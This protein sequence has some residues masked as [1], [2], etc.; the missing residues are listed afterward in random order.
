M[1]VRFLVTLGTTADCAV[2]VQL[3]KGFY[4]QYL[5]ADRG[6][7]TN[8]IITFAQGT[9]IEAVIPPKRIGRYNEITIITFTS[10]ATG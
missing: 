8:E 10:C 1:P 7:D 3:I 4:M 5:L 9:G 6:Y 2:P